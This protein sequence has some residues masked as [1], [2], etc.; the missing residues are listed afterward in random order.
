[1]TNLNAAQV[2]RDYDTSGVPASGAHK[3]NKREARALFAGY[4]AS[5]NLAFTTSMIGK[6][7]LAALNSDLAHVA[8]SLALVMGDATAANNGYYKKSGGVGTG[9]WSRIGD[10]NGPYLLTVTG[11]TANAIEASISPCL[12]ALPGS[13][14]YILVPTANNTGA[15]TLAVDGE[16]PVALKDVFGVA[17][18][19]DSLLIDVPQL[20]IWEVDSY[21]LFLPVNVDASAILAGAVAAQ[22]AAAA[23]AS[24]AAT[25]AAGVNLPS[26]ASG[27][28]GKVL[29]VL[30][31]E[32]GYKLVDGN[33]VASNTVSLL[34]ILT[35]AEAADVLA[36]TNSIDITAKIKAQIAAQSAAFPGST[37]DLTALNG[38]VIV[39]DDW[40]A[41]LHT[42]NLRIKIGNPRIYKEYNSPGGPFKRPSLLKWDWAGVEFHP[43]TPIV[44]MNN[45]QT[46]SERAMIS[47]WLGSGTATGS[48]NN[49]VVALSTVTGAHVGSEVAIL[50]VHVD[51]TIQYPL[52]GSIT[53]SATS[54]NLT[55][56]TTHTIH[57]TP[58]YL[59]VDSETIY[60]TVTAAGAVTVITRG[61]NGTT[62]ASHTSGTVAFW[63]NAFVSYITAIS[64]FNVT[65]NSAPQANFTGAEFWIGAYSHHIT[66][67]GLIDGE[68]VEAT[69]DADAFFMGIGSVLSR[70]CTI[71][72]TGLDIRNT[73]FAGIFEH[74]PMDNHLRVRTITKCGRSGSGLGGS[75]WILGSGRRTHIVADH[76]ESCA[77]T[78]FIDDKSESGGKLGIEQPCDDCSITVASATLMIGGPEI[79][80]SRNCRFDIGHLDS[81][82]AGTIANNDSQTTGPIPNTTNNV[83]TIK[84]D[85]C[86]VAGVG[87]GVTLGV[88]GN[89]IVRGAMAPF[90]KIITTPTDIVVTANSTN[91]V[92]FTVTGATSTS[93]V[94]AMFL[95][96]P[97]GGLG[98]AYAK[99]ASADTVKIAFSNCSGT[100]QTIPAGSRIK[101]LVDNSG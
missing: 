2:F 43:L 35:D 75:A 58:V 74:G 18:A 66:G 95:F 63:M 4:E 56:S 26:I 70:H 32:S 3:V 23:S 100:S 7:S 93:A 53:S 98:I 91:D 65:L 99:G 16:D 37:L 30:S 8:D 71:D 86:I 96:T 64:G 97:L 12:P 42:V 77:N 81:Y 92:N 34:S 19:A 15:V 45:T 25:S 55:G 88:G 83:I 1:M 89:R 76:F 62:A 60:C 87:S 41:G 50:G 68:F 79:S 40:F 84:S 47:S 33:S 36:G 10:L 78:G 54:F 21:R 90:S 38:D 61:A 67:Y 22:A 24:A 28:A 82:T 13:Q 72:A 9:S 17:L 11:G 5:Q 27:D 6:A 14:I 73:P 101:V 80:G 39:T 20:L 94:A 57:D 48:F 49:K 44:T 29:Q 52:A 46:D 85:T 51:E 59:Q 31:D 69:G